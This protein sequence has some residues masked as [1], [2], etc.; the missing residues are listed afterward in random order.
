MVSVT[1]RGRNRGKR[2]PSSPDRITE[3]M[4]KPQ[5]RSPLMTA[6]RNPTPQGILSLDEFH[7]L[8]KDAFRIIFPIRIF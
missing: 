6:F 1:M 2:R 8:S 4:H 5:E 7:V 3:E